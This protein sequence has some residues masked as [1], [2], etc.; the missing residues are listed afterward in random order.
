MPRT[1]CPSTSV[2]KP[3]GTRYGAQACHKGVHLVCFHHSHPKTN[4]ARLV[5]HG[6]LHVF[7]LLRLLRPAFIA[8]LYV[9]NILHWHVRS[10]LRT[11]L[12]SWPSNWFEPARRASASQTQ[13]SRSR[14]LPVCPSITTFHGP[15]NAKMRCTN[16]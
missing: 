9:F 7:L 14:I 10:Q 2:F 4:N 5:A 12:P 13:L 16:S 6:C 3:D 1:L 8:L 11:T 15:E